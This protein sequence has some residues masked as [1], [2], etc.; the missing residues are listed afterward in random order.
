M[1]SREAARPRRS[2]SRDVVAM[3]A[4]KRSGWPSLSTSAVSAPIEEN[5]VCG[6]AA[7]RTSVN[8]PSRLLR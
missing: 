2:F 8:V 7:S 4:T 1:L 5:E 3:S 6:T